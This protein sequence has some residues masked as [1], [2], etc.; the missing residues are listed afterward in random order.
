M[1]RLGVNAAAPGTAAAVIATAVIAKA[2]L[3]RLGRW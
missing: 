2:D 3:H 1:L